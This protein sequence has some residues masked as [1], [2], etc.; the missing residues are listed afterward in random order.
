MVKTMQITE[1]QLSLA[2]FALQKTGF[3]Y[4]MHVFISCCSGE[5]LIL[6]ALAKCCGAGEVTL[7][8]VDDED[9][10]LAERLGFSIYRYHRD[11]NVEV[12]RTLTGGR[13]YDLAFETMGESIAYDAFIDMLKRG[14]TAG[15][16]AKLNEPY[17]FFVKTSV[18]SQIRFVG[19][20]SFDTRSVEIAGTLLAQK[21]LESLL[22][23]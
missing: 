21:K 2:V 4:G 12:A 23:V 9:A 22:D 10:R 13:L 1:E 6:G 20:Q 11:N 8:A 7:G 14:G 16:L 17:T 15:I 3:R 19:L 5:S 18:R